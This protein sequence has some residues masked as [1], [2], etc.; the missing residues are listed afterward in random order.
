MQVELR[1]VRA[2]AAAHHAGSVYPRG[3]GRVGPTLTGCDGKQEEMKVKAKWLPALAAP[4]L[5]LGIATAQPG[6]AA[7]KGVID[8]AT[9]AGYEA[10]ANG[11][12]VTSFQYIQATFTVPSV[13]CGQSP[14]ASVTQLVSLSFNNT[15]MVQESCQ[16]GSP[17]YQASW[18][19]GCNG[20]GDV[21]PLTI[22]PG[23]DVELT[24]HNANITVFDLTT[25]ASASA[26]LS[27]TCGDNPTAEVFTGGSV[28]IV[29]FTQVG[30]RQI[31]VQASNQSTP[32]PLVSPGWS[33]AH[34][35]LRGPSGRVDVKPEA[36]LS[37]T[38]T[39][40]FANDWL[41]PN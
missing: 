29:D 21:M 18:S 5:M 32:N 16:N 34:Y 6:T 33:V 9:R 40:A 28:P 20:H 27:T 13:N 15:A 10:V 31:Q 22:S 24:I 14:T 30:F 2:P 23:D 7:A 37:G 39:S 36:L 4:A 41:A 11:S 3:Y 12:T 25:G 35:I 26:P 19:S 38:F 8:S 1:H 17:S